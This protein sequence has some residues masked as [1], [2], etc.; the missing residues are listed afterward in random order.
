MKIKEYYANP[1]VML[2]EITHRYYWV[3][4]KK[5]IE[6]PSVSQLV[7]Y[8]YPFNAQDIPADALKAGI[9][10]GVCVHNRLSCFIKKYDDIFCEHTYNGWPLK[11][12]N[13]EYNWIKDNLESLNVKE[14]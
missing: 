9:E 7:E 4:N 1:N 5:N 13:K 8:I 10:K 6:G 12:H 2:D 14:I 11:T 3:A